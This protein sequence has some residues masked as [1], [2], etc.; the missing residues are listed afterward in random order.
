MGQT[1]GHDDAARESEDDDPYLVYRRTGDLT[2]FERRYGRRRRGK[3]PGPKGWED[4]RR[5]QVSELQ[6][7]W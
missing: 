3:V 4:S 2:A 7:G 6:S 1:E 5:I